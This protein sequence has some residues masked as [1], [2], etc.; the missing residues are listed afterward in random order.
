MS[1]Y[2]LEKRFGATAVEMGYITTAQLHK[3][4]TIQLNEDL[5]GIAHRLIGQILLER[6]YISK[7]QISEVLKHIGFPLRLWSTDD[8]Y[9]HESQLA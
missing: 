8:E 5:Q 1:D 9:G 7:G 6:A 3:A 2:H 4:M